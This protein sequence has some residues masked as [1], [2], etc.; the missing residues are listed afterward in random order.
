MSKT[1]KSTEAEG[2]APIAWTEAMSVGVPEL[3]EDHKG[4]IRVIN[5]LQQSASGGG[6][7]DVVRQ[8]LVALRRYAEVHFGR[9]ERVMSVCAFPALAHHQQEHRAFVEMMRREGKEFEEKPGERM[10]F[11]TKELVDYLM[12]WLTHHI[13]IEDM[14]YRS[15][16]DHKLTEAR[17]AARS[18]RPSEVSYSDD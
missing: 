10:A 7:E 17:A 14:A 5:Q 8:C 13:M 6:D 1:T 15:F 9:E 12:R 2:M 18:F 3:D 11:V 16:T 4:L